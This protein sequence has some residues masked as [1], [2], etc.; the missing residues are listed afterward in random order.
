MDLRSITPKL[1]CNTQ[2]WRFASRIIA[3]ALVAMIVLCSMEVTAFSAAPRTSYRTVPQTPWAASSSST[4]L[5]MTPNG[6]LDALD[7][8][9]KM[10]QNRSARS[11]LMS[12][13][14]RSRKQ[15]QG[16]YS[17]SKYQKRQSSSSN[18]A[19]A[20]TW[21]K[22]MIYSSF[23]GAG[24]ALQD[25]WWCLPMGLALVPLYYWL[26]LN[27]Y[28]CT[29]SWWPC[30]QLGPLLDWSN[31][32]AY[33]SA[34]VFTFLLSNMAYV[35]GGVY[36]LKYLPRQQQQ[37]NKEASEEVRKLSVMGFLILLAGGVSVI[38]H[39]IQALG[40]HTMAEAWCY[41]DHA[42]AI[43]SGCYFLQHCGLPSARTLAIG[44][45]GLLALA[46]PRGHAY[47]WMHSVWH[48]LSAAAAVSWACERDSPPM[49]FSLPTMRSI[50]F[51]MA[52]P[53]DVKTNEL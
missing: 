35:F 11:A 8:L 30:I 18:V 4:S 10:K 21:V 53:K 33:A 28:P 34:T 51:S 37:H 48:L 40:P 47:P 25:S 27:A 31:S 29:P 17:V 39:S 16:N 26:V 2:R 24:V 44:L 41:M 7:A 22:E 6:Y 3:S 46:L 32:Y 43:T 15:P 1:I 36:L 50:R 9:T 19:Q 13:L 42:V 49:S 38:F 20:T 23:R 45:P 52:S 12:P 5:K 14:F